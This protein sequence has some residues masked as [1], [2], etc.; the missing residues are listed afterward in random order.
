MEAARADRHAQPDLARALRHRN[1]Q[2]FHDADAAN[3]KRDRSHGRQLVRQGLAASLGGAC[4][5]AEVADREIV[6]IA[7]PDVMPRCQ[8]MRQPV[9]RRLHLILRRRLDIDLVDEADQAGLDAI[10]IGDC[11]AK[12]V[13]LRC[14]AWGGLAAGV[15]NAGARS[16]LWPQ[17]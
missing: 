13:D 16:L 14:L 5:L 12:R 4:G 3:Q 9:H 8:G 11:A 15:T 1:Q 2:D 17:D 10:G 7:G 6:R